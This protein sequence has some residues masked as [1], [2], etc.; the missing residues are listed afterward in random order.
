MEFDRPKIKIKFDFIDWLLTLGAFFSLI[1]NFVIVF[2]SQDSLGERIPTRFDFSG[3]PLS[4]AGRGTIWILPLVGAFMFTV[5]MV[6]SRFPEFHNYPWPVT[7]TNAERLYRHSRR[8][9]FWVLNL[10]LF[11][12][13]YSNVKMIQTSMGQGTGISPLFIPL[14]L[15]GVLGSII[16]YFVVGK[17]LV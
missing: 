11:S 3:Q 2:V 7:E 9:I 1:L 6:V 4:W 16:G 5:F 13:L 15:I 12:F 10:V 8:F 17:R 14:L